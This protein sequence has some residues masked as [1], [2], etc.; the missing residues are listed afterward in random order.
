MEGRRKRLV[1]DGGGESW[2]KKWTEGW[3]KSGAGDGSMQSGERGCGTMKEAMGESDYLKKWRINEAMV[4]G[5]VGGGVM[6]KYYVK[7]EE[8]EEEKEIFDGSNA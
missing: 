2:W 5:D 6:E 8:T 1:T 7:V 3:R 4:Y